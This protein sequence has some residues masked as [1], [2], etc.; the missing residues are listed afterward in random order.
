MK[1]CQL[2]CQPRRREEKQ[3][4]PIQIDATIF[5]STVTRPG[6]EQPLL[7]DQG[8]MNAQLVGCPG[9]KVFFDKL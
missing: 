1:Y 8:A 4:G 7:P 9:N 3:D 6:Q 2:R 5:L